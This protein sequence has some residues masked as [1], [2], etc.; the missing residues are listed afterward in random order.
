MNFIYTEL[1]GWFGFSFIIIGYY[2]NSKK[3]E[4]C[5]FIWGIGNILFILYAAL[6]N[7]PPMFL[8]SIFTLG[9]N[10]YGYVEWNK[11]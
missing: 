5:F 8:M 1:L 7:S 2:L 10:I 9:M 11:S 4:K 6:I 3:Q